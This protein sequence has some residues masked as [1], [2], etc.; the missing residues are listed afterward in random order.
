MRDPPHH[1]PLAVR[2]VVVGE[3]GREAGADKDGEPLA[4]QRP[5]YAGDGGEPSRPRE[6]PGPRPER[7][8]GD[9]GFCGTVRTD[10]SR[11][12][13]RGPSRARTR[14]T[15]LPPVAA[16][17]RKAARSA[18]GAKPGAGATRQSPTTATVAPEVPAPPCAAVRFRQPTESRV[19]ALRVQSTTL[20]TRSAEPWRRWPTHP[21]LWR[22]PE[23]G[24]GA[25]V[26]H[27]EAEAAQHGEGAAGRRGGQPEARPPCVQRPGERRRQHR[28]GED[29]RSECKLRRVGSVPRAS[30]PAP[31]PR[32]RRPAGGRL[33][34]P[35]RS[36]DLPRATLTWSGGRAALTGPVFRRA[37]PNAARQEAASLPRTRK[38]GRAAVGVAGACH[39]ATPGRPRA[40]QRCATWRAK[41]LNTTRSTCPVAGR[42]S[43]S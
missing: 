24:G 14:R 31:R 21:V 12:R 5:Q 8:E 19:G 41:K 40:S 7:E 39:S 9:L 37:R 38:C 42:R 13:V 30:V 26:E 3:E 23:E 29:V 1:Q 6:R 33:Q 10:V 34:C 17:A 4:P 11:R 32:A 35:T 36:G 2:R 43:R 20:T 25:G 22:G 15:C 18:S 16:A 28:L 27:R